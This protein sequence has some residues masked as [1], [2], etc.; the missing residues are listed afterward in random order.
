MQ[1]VSFKGHFKAQCG[2]KMAVVVLK[3]FPTPE[4]CTDES[5]EERLM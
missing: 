2:L 4:D 5:I 1:N 3:T